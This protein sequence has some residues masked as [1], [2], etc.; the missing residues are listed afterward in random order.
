[1]TSQPIARARWVRSLTAVTAT[2]VTSAAMIAGT[3]LTAA[4]DP[5]VTQQAVLIKDKSPYSFSY[6]EH[7]NGIGQGDK[8]CYYGGASLC[9]KYPPNR[10][11]VSYSVKLYRLKEREKRYDYYFVDVTARTSARKG[12]GDKGRMS[13]T[14]DPTS[15]INYSTNVYSKSKLK[16]GCHSYPL[17]IGVSMGPINVGT[18]VANFSTCDKADVH[19]TRL[20]SDAV[21]YD[22]YS[23]NRFRTFTM[24][25]WVR[26]AGGLEAHLRGQDGLEGRRLHGDA[27]SGDGVRERQDEVEDDQ[28]QRPVVAAE[29]RRPRVVLTTTAS[30]DGRVTLSRSERLLDPGV[31]A[32]WQGAWTSDVEDLIARRR[33]WLEDRYAPTVVL[34]GSG[35]F[36]ADDVV[37]PV[38]R[39]CGEGRCAR[40]GRPSAATGVGSVVRRRRRSGTD[41]LAVHRRR[42]DRAAGPDL[43]VDPGRLPEAAAGAGC[44]LPGGR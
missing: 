6:Y 40:R 21:R 44:R 30:V 2:V 19:T 9:A 4:A 18:T 1:M 24:Q 16:G 34:E 12:G 3:A 11:K 43:W 15:K 27:A 29:P 41:R 17:E 10:G 35:T 13:V 8:V 31:H 42:G 22:I 28:D 36:V 33:R 23:L 32:R 7:I 14:I 20:K 37:S 38:G 25:K 26:V 39:G 5:P